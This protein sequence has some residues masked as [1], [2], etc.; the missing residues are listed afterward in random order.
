[1]SR[2]M[3][4]PDEHELLVVATGEPAAAAIVEHLEGCEDCRERVDRLRAEL[5]ALRRDFNDKIALR[6]T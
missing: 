6:S 3:T 2:M 5:T 4:C 1:M